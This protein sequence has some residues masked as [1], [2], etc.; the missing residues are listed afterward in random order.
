MEETTTIFAKVRA[1]AERFQAELDG[2]SA[3]GQPNLDDLPLP[4]AVTSKIVDL[5]AQ[6]L[7]VDNSEHQKEKQYLKDAVQQEDGR[8]A[9]LQRQRET[10]QKD[11]D[12]D[13][14]EYNQLQAN[15][16]KGLVPMTRLA[17]TRRQTLFSATRVLQTTALI[18]QVQRQRSEFARRLERVDD[19]RRDSL[20]GKLQDA[21]VRL[22]TIRARLQA[23]GDKLYYAGV[24]RSQLA[25]G[26][27]GDPVIKVYRNDNNTS[28]NIAA[29][30]ETR[31]MPGDVVE[32]RLRLEGPPKFTDSGS[33][34]PVRDEDQKEGV[35]ARK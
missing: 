8:I 33:P 9:T 4:S 32:V 3:L 25:R 5:E 1:Q 13:V 12:S 17:D 11:A 31:L 21:N 16:S 7:S 6:R 18:N 29:D 27:G 19:Q 20:L 28:G 34:A 26:P 24:V 2:K 14:A 35:G 22:T 10:E 15:F 30:E 23:V